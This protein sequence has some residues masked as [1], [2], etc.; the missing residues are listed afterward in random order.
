MKTETLDINLEEYDK[1]L[2][3]KLIKYAHERDLTFNEAIVEILK[4]FLKEF[5]V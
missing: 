3:I 5:E 2:L 1:D 4:S